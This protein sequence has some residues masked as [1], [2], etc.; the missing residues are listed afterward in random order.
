MPHKPL[1]PCKYPGCPNLTEGSY[2]EEHKELVAKEYNRYSRSPDHN[3]KYG[4]A[5]KKVRDRYAKAYRSY[6]RCTS[7]H[8]PKRECNSSDINMDHL[9][10]HI[11]RI[12]RLMVLNIDNVNT[13]KEFINA[14]T[15]STNKSVKR[16]II[17]VERRIQDLNV[18]AC[19]LAGRLSKSPESEYVTL[20]KMIGMNS[21]EHTKLDLELQ[22][23]N[24][25]ISD[26]KIT[27]ARVL[28]IIR[29]ARKEYYP[30]DNRDVIHR[31]VN[32]IIINPESI[33]VYIDLTNL[34]EMYDYLNEDRVLLYIS[35][36]R[37]NVADRIKLLDI[38]Y[39]GERLKKN[40][41][42]L[43]S[44]IAKD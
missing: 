18:E 7:R 34:F 12:M 20:T 23:L 25:C 6:Y 21:V 36:K 24:E 13:F 19:E 35:E 1:K 29:G 15:T 32:K 16:K 2:C 22:K 17:D 43:L 28:E 39:S 30:N 14:Y 44:T 27:N 26:V 9:N 11:K 3:K 4:R 41:D 37:E 33:D 10:A 31:I 8:T 5:W 38:D 42:E 40:L